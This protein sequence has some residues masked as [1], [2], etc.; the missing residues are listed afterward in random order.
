MTVAARLAAFAAVLVLVLLAGLG[1]GRAVGPVGGEQ[2]AGGHDA[3][4][5]DGAAGAHD[6][7]HGAGHG[8]THAA[9]DAGEPTGI[10]GLAVSEDGYTLRPESSTLAVGEQVFRFVVDGPDGSPVTELD[11]THD[12][13]LHLIVVRRDG[14][15]FQHLHPEQAADGT[16]TTPLALD[17]AGAYRAY[18]DFAPAGEPA[19]TLAV[20][21]VVPG[22][23]IAEPWP[24]PSEVVEVD[25]LEVR[26]DGHLI[27]G[28]AA[29]LG[30]TVTRGG[31]A[32]E[33]ERYLGAAGHLV[34]LREGDLGYL[35]VHADGDALA[36]DAAAP[37]AGRYRL[38]LQFQVDGT[39]RTAELVVEAEQAHA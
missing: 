11:V 15:G 34:A 26:F 33:L 1:L 37:S 9:G 16:W 36:F 23:L 31:Q 32:V 19:R 38:Y 10:T 6:A 12:R 7:G 25:G 21:L 39:V 5:P 20:D 29:E 22:E 35:H 18:A 17:R 28:E 27:A 2:A 30:F 14:T 8:E 4:A 3:H 13:E 24:A